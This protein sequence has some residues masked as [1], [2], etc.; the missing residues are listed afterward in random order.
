MRANRPWVRWARAMNERMNDSQRPDSVSGSP[1]ATPARLRPI[2]DAA[3]RRVEELYRTTSIAALRDEAQRY[4]RRSFA[5]ALRCS[6]PAIIA[7]IK[8]A[9]PSRGLFREDF[10]P[11]ALAGSYARGGAAAISVVTEP[12]FFQGDGQW[13]AAVRAAAQ[14][15]VLRKDFIVDPI[16][17]YES[18][19]LGADAVLLI[20]RILDADR[21][22]RLSAAA[23]TLQLDILYEAHDEDDLTKL[24]D[25]A[26]SVVGINAR[27][28]DDFS[29]D[30]TAFAR[31]RGLILPE[32]IAVAESGIVGPAQLGEFSRLGYRA[33]L[34]GEALVCSDNPEEL[35]RSLLS[36]GEA[37]S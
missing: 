28:L 27:N 35:L 12:E 32:A 10:D 36:Q 16:Q 15:P 17:I 4:E 26:P 18:A 13:V 5:D 9:S 33:F 25:C 24:A 19:A 3:L 34:I 14:L 8:K 1:L 37:G 30:T 23:R 6:E 20:V 29:I 22:H 11:V 7:E 2:I 21:L 31:L